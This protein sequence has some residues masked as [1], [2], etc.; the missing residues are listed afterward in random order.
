LLINYKNI[1]IWDQVKKYLPLQ[2]FNHS[3]VKKIVFVIVAVLMGAT[4]LTSCRFRKETETIIK[5]VVTTE[6]A[7]EEEVVF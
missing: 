5:E 7:P 4:A 6:S 2:S 1:S 3:T